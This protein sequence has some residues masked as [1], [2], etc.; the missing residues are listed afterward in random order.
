MDQLNN[1][2]PSYKFYMMDVH[3]PLEYLGRLCAGND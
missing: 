2:L 1:Q 3:I